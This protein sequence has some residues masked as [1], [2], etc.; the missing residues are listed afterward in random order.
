MFVLYILTVIAF[1]EK[2]TKSMVSNLGYG[3]AKVINGI[4][5]VP[6]RYKGKK[7]PPQRGRGGVGSPCIR[8]QC[9]LRVWGTYLC[10]SLLTLHIIFLLG[11]F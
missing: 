4:N 10:S 2:I 6:L 7:V 8:S 3:E 5:T 9:Q 1:G 11:R